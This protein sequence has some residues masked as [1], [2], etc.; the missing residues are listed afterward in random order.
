MKCVPACVCCCQCASTL[1]STVLAAARHGCIYVVTSHVGYTLH[2]LYCYDT[3]ISQARL[4]CTSDVGCLVVGNLWCTH[5]TV[6]L[7]AELGRQLGV[8][9]DGTGATWQMSCCATCW[10]ASCSGHT[11]QKTK[12]TP[13]LHSF[14]CLQPKCNMHAAF[15]RTACNNA[16][17]PSALV[18]PHEQRRV[19]LCQLQHFMKATGDL[20]TSWIA[21]VYPYI[22]HSKAQHLP[23][24]GAAL[25]GARGGTARRSI[26]TPCCR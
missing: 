5:H 9:L 8:S 15:V 10:C 4:L 7:L 16:V 24:P 17:Q 26:A 25:P 6:Y 3:H 12:H 22:S 11:M 20:T 13:A 18:M 1:H 2:R 23:Q 21:G 19:Q 14:S